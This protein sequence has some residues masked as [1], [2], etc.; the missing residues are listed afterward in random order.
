MDKAAKT[1]FKEFMDSCELT[2]YDQLEADFQKGKGY[3]KLINRRN[4]LYSQLEKAIPETLIPVLK[5]FDDAISSIGIQ[6]GFH[7]YKAGFSD[8]SELIQ[9][10]LGDKKHIN[11]YSW[12][13]SRKNNL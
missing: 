9:I 2:R 5:E 4:E 8:A 6:R 10:L 12:R 7:F 13:Y 1:G 11:K 3:L